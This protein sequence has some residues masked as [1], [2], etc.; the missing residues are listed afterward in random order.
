MNKQQRHQQLK[1]DVRDYAASSACL[2]EEQ[3]Y[4]QTI[5]KFLDQQASVACDRATHGHITASVLVVDASGEHVLLTHHKK[6][7]IWV[8]LGGH[9]EESD[10]TVKD[11]ALREAREESGM[12]GLTFLQEGIFDIDVHALPNAC[13]YHYDIRYVLQAP[14]GAQPM[15]SDE[16]H[17]VRFVK[18]GEVEQYVQERS[19]LR[20]IEKLKYYLCG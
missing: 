17:A 11:A 10:A 15:V 2:L 1:D 19:V 18:L 13:A 5:Q 4:V 8:Q 14:I 3:P 9:V 20:M 12:D 7:N 6:F 16:S